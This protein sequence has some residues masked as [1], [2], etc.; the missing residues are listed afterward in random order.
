MQSFIKQANAFSSARKPFFFLIDF[1]QK[2]PVLLP[3]AECSS[4]QIFFQFP[5]CNNVSFSDF[6]K[7]FEFSRRPLKF[8]RY[9]TAFELVKNEIQK[10]NSYL[11][12]LAFP[13]QIQTN[14]SLKEIFIKSQAKY[15]LLYQDKF[16]CFSPETFIHIKDNK[17]YSYPMKG[18]INASEENAKQKLLDSKKEF[19]DIYINFNDYEKELKKKDQVSNFSFVFI[20]DLLKLTN[21]R[22]NTNFIEKEYNFFNNEK[23]LK[24]IKNEL[25]LTE[26]EIKEIKKE[27]NKFNFKLCHEGYSL[28]KKLFN[29]GYHLKDFAEKFTKWRMKKNKKIKKMLFKTNEPIKIDNYFVVKYLII[30][31]EEK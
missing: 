16:V 5:T 26:Y 9:Q 6:D 20:R 31:L 18:T 4:H 17:I 30:E 14:Y 22:E 1:E 11:L 21:L 24:F 29:L 10:G 23:A 28:N 27:M 13:T 7:Q 15:K 25:D 3:L 12:N 8:D 2:Q 19:E